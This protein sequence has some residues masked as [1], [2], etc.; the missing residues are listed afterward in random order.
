MES[1]FDGDFN[2]TIYGLE[3]GTHETYEET[4]FLDFV[5]LHGTLEAK[6][7]FDLVGVT[8]EAYGVITAC[9]FGKFD[10]EVITHDGQ[11]EQGILFYWHDNDSRRYGLI[12]NGAD[13]ES[14]VYAQ[15]KFFSRA[16]II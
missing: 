1:G 4:R 12:V 15:D 7:G 14:M 8:E 3:I 10:V 6:N 13:T 5:Y 16:N 9:H 2:M 11:K